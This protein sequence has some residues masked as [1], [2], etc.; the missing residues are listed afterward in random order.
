ME[1]KQ[2]LGIEENSAAYVDLNLA[3]GVVE[4][5]V[6]PSE[7]PKIPIAGVSLNPKNTRQL[8]RAL[9][10]AMQ[11]IEKEAR[12]IILFFNKSDEDGKAYRLLRDSEIQ[13]EFRTP[14]SGERCLEE[15]PSRPL[16]VVGYSKYIGFEEI[17]KFV[18]DE[19]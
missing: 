14:A 8:I 5:V 15:D 2:I 19:D 4:L 10:S 6:E 13:C 16:L 18:N 3:K 9:R 12:K 1:R 11:E 17:E 7:A